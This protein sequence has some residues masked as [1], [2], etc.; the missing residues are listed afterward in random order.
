MDNETDSQKPHCVHVIG[1]GR[2]GCVHVEALLRTG[3]IED[4]LTLPGT[5]L[6]VLMLDIGEEDMLIAGDYAR[7]MRTRID[8]RG[9]EQDRYN[10]DMVPLAAPDSIEFK[11]SLDNIRE[12]FTDAGGSGLISDLPGGQYPESYGKHTPRAIAKAI[13]AID[14]YGNDSKIAAALQRFSKNI[15]KSTSNSTV[16]IAFGLAGGTGT[17]MA[18]TISRELQKLNLGENATIVGVGQLSHS[19]DGNYYDSVAQTLALRELDQPTGNRD[20]FPGGLF[21]ISTEHSWQRLTAYTNTGERAVRDH[22]RQLVTNRF[23]ADSFMRWSL[24]NGSEHLIRTLQD[25]NG[26]TI[27]FN[28][29]KLS[30]PGVQVLPGEP[31]SRWDS[32]LNQWVEFIPRF[33]GIA[34]S[35][36]SKKVA[37][38]IYSARYMN[39]DLVDKSIKNIISASY[40]GAGEGEYLSR[41]GEFFDELTAYANIIFFNFN[42]DNIASYLKGESK[43]TAMDN[44]AIQLET[45]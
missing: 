28:V 38:Y 23:V 15:R 5:S 39:S 16:F 6:S 8:Q 44:K 29:A 14:L 32:V 24:E 22:F 41:Q 42:K 31:R 43:L 3:E 10:F 34:E 17:G 26:G 7:S 45:T 2:T 35:F 4:N 19:G 37:T 18:A 40:I 12:D 11:R 25:G 9:I 27:M 1:I 20:A 30:H 21:I 36:L 33:S 13:C